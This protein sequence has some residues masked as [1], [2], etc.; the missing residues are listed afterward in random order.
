MGT[1]LAKADTLNGLVEKLQTTDIP[2]GCIVVAVHL[3]DHPTPYW[4]AYD[5]Y[6]VNAYCARL[7][8]D[9]KEYRIFY[10][11]PDPP[12]SQQNELL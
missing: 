3:H 6:N 12:R 10:S 4:A 8:E 1:A 5:V 11:I 7:E 2:V 9:N